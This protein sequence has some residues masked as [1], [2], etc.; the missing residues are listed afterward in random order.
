MGEPVRSVGGMS[1]GGKRTSSMEPRQTFLPAIGLVLLYNNTKGFPNINK[2]IHNT[3]L[4]GA[5]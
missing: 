5:Q 1:G 2:P 4:I 3:A